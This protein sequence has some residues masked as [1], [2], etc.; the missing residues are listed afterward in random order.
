[1]EVLICCS[2]WSGTAGLKFLKMESCCVTQT[3][4]QWC[5]LSSLQPQPPG[6]RQFSHLSLLSSRDY[7]R[8]PPHLANFCRRGFTMLATLISNSR[9]RDPPGQED[10]TW[11]DFL[12]K[13]WKQRT[14]GW[15]LTLLPRLECTSVI[16]ARCSLWLLGSSDSHA[17]ASRVA[18][19]I[20]G[21][22]HSGLI[23]AVLVEMGFHHVGQADHELLTS[24]DLPTLSSQSAGVTS[25]SHCTRPIYSSFFRPL[26]VAPLRKPGWSYF[27]S[28]CHALYSLLQIQEE[29]LNVAHPNVFRRVT[30][31]VWRRL[32]LE[33]TN[34]LLFLMLQDLLGPVLLGTRW[35]NLP[36]NP[37][38]ELEGEGPALSP[39]LVCSGDH[40]SRQLQT[41][42]LK[43]SSFFSHLEIGSPYIAQVGLKLLVSSNSPTLASQSAGITG[44]RHH[45]Q[46]KL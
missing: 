14:K 13:V 21:C 2:G 31:I 33:S 32:P 46:Q 17:S 28:E 6:F 27:T 44:M 20:G 22:H 24:S 9:P 30:A 43:Q 36:L 26:R 4:V 5:D 11:P 25:V 19:I 35:V 23:F 18:G 37:E 12:R 38:A 29:W 15:S 34:S 42:A 45:A 10:H 7:R 3:G 41:T 1:M 40:K 16:S 39:M 8:L